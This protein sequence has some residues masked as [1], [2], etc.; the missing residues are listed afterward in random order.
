[1]P[2]TET[3]EKGLSER[4]MER[5]REGREGRRKGG[6]TIRRAAEHGEKKKEGEK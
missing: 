5:M 2:E 4:R 1:M 3:W 6:R